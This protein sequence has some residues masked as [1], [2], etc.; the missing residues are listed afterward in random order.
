[1]MSVMP[2]NRERN[3]GRVDDRHQQHADDAKREE[4]MDQWVGVTVRLAGSA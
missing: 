3:E 1:M 2:G 4:Q